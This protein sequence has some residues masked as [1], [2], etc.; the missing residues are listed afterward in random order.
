MSLA[1]KLGQWPEV[2]D[3]RGQCGSIYLFTKE[4]VDLHLGSR[5][6]LLVYFNINHLDP[7]TSMSDLEMQNSMSQVHD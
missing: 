3:S 2:P 6:G 5:V 7:V 4:E 1:I